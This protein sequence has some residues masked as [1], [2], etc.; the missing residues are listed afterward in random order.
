MHLK[1]IVSK[2]DVERDVWD[3]NTINNRREH[4]IQFAIDQWQDLQQ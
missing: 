4:L 1:D 2:H 3:E